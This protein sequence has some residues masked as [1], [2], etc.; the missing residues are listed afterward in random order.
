MY[1]SR[2][3][4]SRMR[5]CGNRGLATEEGMQRGRSGVYPRIRGQTPFV[6]A[7]DRSEC[8]AGRSGRKVADATAS[9]THSRHPTACLGNMLL[10]LGFDVRLGDGSDD[11][12]HHFSALE[13]QEHGNRSDVES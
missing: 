7:R 3:L 12:I 5:L 10:Q 13:E 11:L 4:G 2:V 9:A 8:P 1:A 6:D